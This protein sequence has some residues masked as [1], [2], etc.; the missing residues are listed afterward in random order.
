MSEIVTINQNTGIASSELDGITFS[1][2]N[3][4][5]GYTTIDKKKFAHKNSQYD[6][7]GGNNTDKIFNVVDIDWN[8]AQLVLPQILG[9]NRTINTTGELLKLIVEIANKLS[10]PEPVEIPVITLNPNTTQTIRITTSNSDDFKEITATITDGNA[11]NISWSISPSN[12]Q[13]TTGKT[14]KLNK[15]TGSNVKI[16]AN[17]S[18]PNKG[19][20]NDLTPSEP[21]QNFTEGQISLSTGFNAG[22]D[23]DYQCTLVASYPNASDVQL[24]IKCKVISSTSANNYIWHYDGVSGYTFSLT[25]ELNGLQY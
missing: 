4:A 2:I 12:M 14:F 25:P 3:L 10:N 21:T 11:S 5:D 22:A 23:K 1:N 6:P 16:T 17:D 13:G 7:N 8:G 19:T 24:I 18:T 15:T 20:L 9:G